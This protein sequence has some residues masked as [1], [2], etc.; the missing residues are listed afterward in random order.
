MG[1]LRDQNSRRIE[2]TQDLIQ[3]VLQR[4]SA[5]A[6]TRQQTG[7][8]LRTVTTSTLSRRPTKT[9]GHQRLGDSG[10]HDILPTRPNTAR[11]NIEGYRYMRNMM[12]DSVLRAASVRG[13]LT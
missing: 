10:A 7:R 1:A 8:R 13:C 6:A 2:L 11:S 5:I 3:S 12:R 4:L 9:I